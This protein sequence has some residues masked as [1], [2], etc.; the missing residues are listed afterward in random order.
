[1]KL[2]R[3]TLLMLVAVLALGLAA[4]GTP[5][6]EQE[7]QQAVE[8]TVE[9]TQADV[10]S[11]F[12]DLET[13]VNDALEKA[14]N[15]PSQQEEAESLTSDL[16]DIS[17]RVDDAIKSGGDDQLETFENLGNAFD[18][19]INQVNTLAEGASGEQEVALK[20]LTVVLVGA[21]EMLG[22]SIRNMMGVEAK[23]TVVEEA[24]EATEAEATQE[25]EAA[26]AEETAVSEAAEDE[27]AAAE[28]EATAA[29]GADDAEA[30]VV[31]EEEEAVEAEE[32]PAA[33]D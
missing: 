14:G 1:M 11:I 27:A 3:L 2:S 13:A 15:L 33:S 6:P 30:T 21:K 16:Q 12:T 23:A 9:Q 10:D 26:E 28:A 31:A 18:A 19:V 7:V 8:A 25:A 17:S 4:C 29:V 32:T 5:S 22:D 20:E 24:V